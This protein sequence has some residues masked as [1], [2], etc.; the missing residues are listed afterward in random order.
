MATLGAQI[1]PSRIIELRRLLADL[2]T[3]DLGM[4]DESL[5]GWMNRPLGR[6]A[7]ASVVLPAAGSSFLCLMNT[8]AAGLMVIERGKVGARVRA[9]AVSPDF[10]RRGLARTMLEAADAFIAEA[11]LNWLW[12]QV[13]ASNTPATACALSSGYRRYRPQFLRRERVGLMSLAL[14]HAH[15]EALQAKD[16]G[17]LVTQWA[18]TAARQGDAWCSELASQ[19]LLPL[20]Y[21]RDEGTSY[22]LVSGADEVG[23]AH[24]GGDDAQ[25]RLWLWL[26]ESIWNTPR[27]MNVLKAVLDTLGEVPPALEIEFG[28]AGHLRASLEAYKSL[29]FKPALRDAVVMAKRVG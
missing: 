17:Q 11:G 3:D 22:L 16:A 23:V 29:G 4:L 19:D 10:R 8:D 28:S 6:E 1:V 15:V 13:P 5:G 2:S 25:R 21:P 9:L 7:L 20:S 26:D 27:E 14:G 24:F 18:V 12:M